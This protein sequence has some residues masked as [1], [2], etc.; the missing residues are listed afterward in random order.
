MKLIGYQI[1]YA[2][3]ENEMAFVR[4]R[5]INSGFTKALK[6][7]KERLGDGTQREIARIEFWEVRS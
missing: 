2:E 4:A 1:T 7:A 3:G 6:R 5:D